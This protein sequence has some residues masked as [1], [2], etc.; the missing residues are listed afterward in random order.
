MIESHIASNAHSSTAQ[1]IP[2][3][4]EL[5]AQWADNIID[6]SERSQSINAA[7]APSNEFSMLKKQMDEMMKRMEAIAKQVPQ[8]KPQSSTSSSTKSDDICFF[9]RKYGNGKHENKKCDEGC[10]LHK[11]WLAA[12]KSK[13][14]N[15]DQKN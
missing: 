13:S 12:Q 9:H 2:L 5:V 11:F 1:Q 4:T 15:E 10:R 7:S 8:A 3:T 14:V 6:G